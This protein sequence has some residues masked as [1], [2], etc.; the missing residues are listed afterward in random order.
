MRLNELK[1]LLGE[2]PGLIPVFPWIPGASFTRDASFYGVGFVDEDLPRLRRRRS[3]IA[4]IAISG[5]AA[6]MKM[7]GNPPEEGLFATITVVS[8]WV[9]APESSVAVT[10]IV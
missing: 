5:I 6:I 4:T 10:V 9:L 2:E 1:S 7:S 3:T 8:F